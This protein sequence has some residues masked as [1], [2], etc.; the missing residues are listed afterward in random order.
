MKGKHKGSH[1]MASYCLEVV[2]VNGFVHIFTT[3]CRRH[4]L[5]WNII[6]QSEDNDTAI[7]FTCL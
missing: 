1:S 4:S 6:V 3:F 7:D 2:D 5:S